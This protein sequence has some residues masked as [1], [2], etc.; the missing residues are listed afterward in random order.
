MSLALLALAAASFAIGTTEFVIMGL[1]PEVAADLGVTIPA[2]GLLISGYAI[3]VV[4]GAPIVAL[5]VAK[6][7]RRAALMALMA[8]FTLGNLA[9]AFAPDYW[10]L[11]AA[12]VATA[13][14]HGSFFGIGAVVAAEIVPA[15]QKARAMALMFAGLTI[16]NVLGVPFGT[17]LGQWLGWRATFLVVTAIGVVAFAAIAAW[18]PRHLSGSTGSFRGEIRAIGRPQV[19]LA[20][21]ISVLASMSMFSVFTYIAPLLR[22]VT[23]VSPEGVTQILLVFGLGLTVGNFLGGRLA[24]WRLMPALM[25]ALV[26]IA[27]VL[28]VFAETQHTLMPAVVTIFVW[29]VAIFAA[30]AP[31]QLRVVTAAHGAPNLASSLNQAAFNLGNATGAWLGGAALTS[32]AGYADLPWIGAGLAVAAALVT[33]F[34]YTIERSALA[35]AAR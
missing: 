4:I 28:A 11:M 7:P 30:V 24:D 33:V 5:S 9:C 2:A 34:S 3:G 12:R 21:T 25:T 16:A 14:A 17:G 13:F 31:L 32:G 35:A 29:G 27:L 19:V 15:N 10:S 22:E 8:I 6:L 23:G 26:A 18:L 20:M 1:L